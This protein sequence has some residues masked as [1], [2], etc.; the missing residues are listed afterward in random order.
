[1]VQCMPVLGNRKDLAGPESLRLTPLCF[2]QVDTVA[3]LYSKTGKQFA[4]IG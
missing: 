3:V 1:M 2:G 4:E